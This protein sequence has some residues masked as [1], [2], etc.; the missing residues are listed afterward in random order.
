MTADTNPFPTP[1]PWSLH[2]GD[3]VRRTGPT[4]G[5]LQPGMI[6]RV[7]EQRQNT[8][9]GELEVR[10]FNGDNRWYAIDGFELVSRRGVLAPN[11]EPMSPE[12]VVRFEEPVVPWPMTTTTA[13]TWTTTTATNVPV[14]TPLTL[15][16]RFNVGDRVRV[17]NN[18][19][20]ADGNTIGYEGRVEVIGEEDG[21][22]KY[23]LTTLSGTWFYYESDLAPAQG[24]QGGVLRVG[25]YVRIVRNSAQAPNQYQ[26]TIH[27]IVNI[28]TPDRGRTKYL[29]R[30]PG[31]DEDEWY[32]YREDL[33]YAVVDQP[34]QKQ[35][36]VCKDFRSFLKSKAVVS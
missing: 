3:V 19:S 29:F 10:L 16:R 9:T 23:Y 4:W 36:Q 35:K 26:G 34:Y 6:S 1:P 27:E 30:Y 5:A 32:Q 24:L 33:E 20:L 17:I 25:D 14:P 21:R 22:T 12:Q 31:M 13:T 18:L 11:G 28:L 7:M 2:I 15:P 8:L